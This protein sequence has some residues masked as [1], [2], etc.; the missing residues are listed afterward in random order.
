MYPNEQVIKQRKDWVVKELETL[1]KQHELLTF[2]ISLL[3]QEH[4]VLRS[5]EGLLKNKV[6]K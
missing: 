2:N 5:L 1:Y 3:E 4:A 6:K